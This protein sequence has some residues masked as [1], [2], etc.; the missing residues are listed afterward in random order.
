M[1]VRSSYDN[2]LYNRNQ[3]FDTHIN[4][5]LLFLT[6][7]KQDNHT[8]ICLD[9]YFADQEHAEH[10]YDDSFRNILNAY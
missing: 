5:N 7:H 6:P 8:R 1:G 10:N 4:A 2:N 3:Y 9:L